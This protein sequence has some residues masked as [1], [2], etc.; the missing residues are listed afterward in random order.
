MYACLQKNI[1]DIPNTSIV[2]SA[3]NTCLKKNNM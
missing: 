2:V 1:K 3:L